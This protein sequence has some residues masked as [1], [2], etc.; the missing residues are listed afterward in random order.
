MDTAYALVEGAVLAGVW[1]R[2]RAD[3]ALSDSMHDLVP[4]AGTRTTHWRGL[5]TT[6]PSAPIIGT[7]YG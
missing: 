3:F 6:I 2:V 4:P 7:R 5:L 1:Y